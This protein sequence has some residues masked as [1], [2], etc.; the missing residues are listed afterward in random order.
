MIL[1]IRR[2][3]YTIH[4]RRSAV[5]SFLLLVLLLFSSLLPGPALG[6]VRQPIDV[7]VIH[8]NDFYGRLLPSLVKSVHETVPVG[9]AAY[10]AYKFKTF[11]E[12]KNATYGDMAR[13]I[14]LLFLQKHS[15]VSPGLEGRSVIVP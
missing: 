10:L 14:F 1:I 12:G 9:G 5:T 2:D 4:L 7:T 3:T 8:I 13:D 15:P 6:E 11:T